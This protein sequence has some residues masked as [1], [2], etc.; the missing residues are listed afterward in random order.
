MEKRAPLTPSVGT[1]ILYWILRT[2]WTAARLPILAVLI[3]L[4]P[5]AT[6]V[7]GGLAILGLFTTF[8]F[9]VVGSDPRFPFWTFLAISI[10]FALALLLYDGL[11]ALFSRR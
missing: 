8:F 2:L 9:K 1:Q 6:L 10:G 11:L 3:V 5:I 4:R 7:L